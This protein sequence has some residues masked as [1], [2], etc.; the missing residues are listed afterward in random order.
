[1]TQLNKDDRLADSASKI[2][3]PFTVDPTMRFYSP[4]EN[5]DA[6]DHPRVAPYLDW[7]ANKWEPPSGSPR[8][9]LIIPCTKSKPY[10]TSRE[11][12][13]INGALLDAGWEPEGTGKPPEGLYD[14]ID[15]GDDPRLLDLSTMTR[16]GVSLDRIVVS[17]P[18][19]LVPY[20][21]VYSWQDGPSPASGYDDPGLFESRGTSVS[22][23]R[24]DH[25]AT[26][27]ASG[28]WTWGP[29]ER[30]AYVSAHNTLVDVIHTTLTRVRD[31]YLGVAAWTSPGLTHR[32]FLMGEDQRRAE[33]LPLTRQGTTGP[34]ALRGVSDLTPGLVDILPTTDQLKQSRVDLAKRLKSEGRTHSPGAVRAV[35]ARGDGHDT[36]L[37]L[38]ELLT[39]LMAWIDERASSGA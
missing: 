14:A 22:P 3:A 7:I 13:S 19:G 18:L 12:R 32:S 9:A 35:Y 34:C 25:S 8:L 6:F 11:H 38:P 24:A 20:T 16:N 15:E 4:Q 21:D 30:E 10:S 23:W 37:G 27:N 17:E 5:V 1:M 26:Q 33:G 31:R 36:P 2:K 29:A 39:N 28:K